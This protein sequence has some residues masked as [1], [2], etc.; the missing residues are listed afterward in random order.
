MS[1]MMFLN[2][3]AVVIVLLSACLFRKASM[4]IHCLLC[5]IRVYIYL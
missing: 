4:R 5:Y 1:R 2:Q 3:K